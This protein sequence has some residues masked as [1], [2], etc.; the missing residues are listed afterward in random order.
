MTEQVKT[1]LRMFLENKLYKTILIHGKKGI[2]KSYLIKQ[3][4]G[5]I[6]QTQISPDLLIL[7]GEPISVDNV[8]QGIDFSTTT[9]INKDKILV[10]DGIDTMSHNA[11]NAMLKLL[12][13]PP[14]NLYIFLVAT[15]IY[16]LPQTIRSRCL[17]IYLKQPNIESFI[18]I[19][20][21]NRQD[22][23]DD[24][25]RYLYNALEADINA[26]NSIIPDLVT[27]IGLGTPYLGDL[28]DLMISSPDDIIV[29]IILFELAKR[30]KIANSAQQLY[31]LEKIDYLNNEYAKIK[32]YNL[33][34]VNSV[35]SIVQSLNL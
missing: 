5:S 18:E 7:S 21:S 12:E 29:K 24:V 11:I 14:L 31:F 1:I 30:A 33:N 22:L 10:F 26:T 35:Y 17:Q 13:E 20:R 19:V 28:L 9:P 25:I 32:K 16:N 8:R 4:A 15:N 2:G 23:K 3:I 34:L 6:L 27:I